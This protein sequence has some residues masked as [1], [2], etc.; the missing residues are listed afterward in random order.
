MGKSFRQHYFDDE[1]DNEYEGES[2]KQTLRE[3]RR[4]KR[5]KRMKKLETDYD[6]AEY[7]N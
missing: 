2:K 6:D 3:R 5:L 1:L 4:Q 7:D